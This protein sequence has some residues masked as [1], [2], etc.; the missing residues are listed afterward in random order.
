MG[1]SKHARWVAY[2]IDVGVFAEKSIFPRL[3]CDENEDEEEGDEQGSRVERN[4]AENRDSGY[5]AREEDARE[6]SR[7]SYED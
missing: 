5:H 7:D 3:E 4:V 6:R 1:Q 2:K